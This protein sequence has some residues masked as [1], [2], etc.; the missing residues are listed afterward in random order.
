M[1]Y[2]QPTPDVWKA[3][4]GC[5]DGTGDP[6]I[7]LTQCDF[8]ANCTTTP[9]DWDTTPDVVLS[10]TAAGLVSTR[11]VEILSA[12]DGSQHL[13]WVDFS[14]SNAEPEVFYSRKCAGSG[15]WITP[16]E[17]WDSNGWST[18][19]DVGRPHM[20]VI[21]NENRKTVHIV[22]AAN[23]TNPYGGS[24]PTDGMIIYAHREWTCN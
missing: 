2:A 24:T 9:G 10:R 12:S 21:D 7:C 18:W 16:V 17:L 3:A 19:L 14:G 5:T 23:N 4:F 1:W 20:A 22:F 13:L 11:N 8:T 6:S 15:G